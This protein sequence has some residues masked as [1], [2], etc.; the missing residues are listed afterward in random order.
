M[1]YMQAALTILAH[2]EYPLTIG[3]L[4]AVA[5]ADGLIRPRG[6]TPD[7]TMSSVLY[8]RMAADADA[9]IISRGGRFWL[10]GRPL[11]E[12]EQGYLAQ[13]ARR[14]RSAGRRPC[15]APALPGAPAT[16]LPPPPLHL[17]ADVRWHSVAARRRG[18]V[19]PRRGASAPWRARA[20]ARP[21]CWRGWR[22]AVPARAGVGRG[23]DR[24]AAHRA[25]V[26]APGLSPRQGSA[27]PVEHAGRGA[28][29]YVLSTQT[30]SRRW[31]CWCA[32]S[33]TACTTT[34]PGAR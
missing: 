8:R 3:E 13:R 33:A 23:A 25:A 27:A 21:R 19:L 16:I 20:P 22:A 7:R 30:I 1:T 5:V 15:A 17:P 11:P 9:P 6:R 28:A 10:R 24:R 2:A 32:G 4:T 31:R 26:G 18:D 12:Q 29:A 34:M 14:A